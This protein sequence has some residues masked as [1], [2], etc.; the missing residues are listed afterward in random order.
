MISHLLLEDVGRLCMLASGPLASLRSTV[1][2]LRDAFGTLYHFHG[3]FPLLPF[4][5]GL[6]RSN[7]KFI[8]GA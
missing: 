6:N 7:L 2:T 4:L 1:L 5:L 8:T 3:T